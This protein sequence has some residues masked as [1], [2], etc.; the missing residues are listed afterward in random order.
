MIRRRKGGWRR[1]EVTLDIKLK[2][3]FVEEFQKL[4]HSGKQFQ[5]FVAGAY[6]VKQD[7][8]D[9]LWLVVSS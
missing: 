4:N 5:H 2:T 1:Y 8:E 3:F 9:W 7:P 6:L